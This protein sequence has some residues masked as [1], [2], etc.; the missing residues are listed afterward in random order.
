M[1]ST[2]LPVGVKAAELCPRPPRGS[3][4]AP[5]PEVRSSG[6][7]LSLALAIRSDVDEEGLK[8]YCYIYRNSTEAPTLR[9]QPGDEVAI[10]LSNELRP[11]GQASE[12]H[13]HTGNVCGAG[14]MTA[15]STNLHFHG[16]EIPPV[17]HQDEVIHTSIQP[18]EPAFEYR[19]RIPRNQPPGLY[20]YHPHPHGYSEAQVLA[21]LRCLAERPEL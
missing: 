19:F 8:R 20:W 14:I 3:A 16:L 13:R 4:I 9:V 6:G 21:R 10:E 12:A 15:V 1:I 17:C 18:L 2:L 11:E 5:P 7:H